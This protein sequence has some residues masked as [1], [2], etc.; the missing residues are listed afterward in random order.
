MKD[1]TLV[2]NKIDFLLAIFKHHQ[3]SLTITEQIAL[4]TLWEEACVNEEEYE[5]AGAIKRELDK[6]INQK[7]PEPKEKNK[8]KWYNKISEWFKKKL[9]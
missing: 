8:P 2:E 3:P 9:F 6:I 5:I 7:P 4:L 1:L